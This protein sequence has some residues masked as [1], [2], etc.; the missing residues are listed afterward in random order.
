[1]HIEQI[2]KKK[3][4]HAKFVLAEVRFVLCNVLLEHNM[5]THYTRKLDARKTRQTQKTRSLNYI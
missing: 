1:M 4:R 5:S 2:N 3:Q